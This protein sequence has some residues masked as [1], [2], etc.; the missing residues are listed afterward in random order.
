MSLAERSPEDVTRLKENTKKYSAIVEA[1]NNVS[2]LQ[3]QALRGMIDSASKID[4]S[5][6]GKPSQ[7]EAKI[8][9]CLLAVLED[10]H[11]YSGINAEHVKCHILA[12]RIDISIEPAYTTEAGTVRSSRWVEGHGDYGYLQEDHEPDQYVPTQEARAFAEAI[13]EMDC[14][15]MQ[16]T[17]RKTPFLIS[18]GSRTTGHIGS[19][20]QPFI[21]ALNC[22][23]KTH[24]QTIILPKNAVTR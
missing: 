13:R 1:R 14:I 16:K 3:G 5:Q 4:L 17:G 24:D 21:D 12:N 11:P 22:F 10:T 19:G 2:L 6:I 18:S 15:A 23:A 20:L 7:L 8:K 9:S